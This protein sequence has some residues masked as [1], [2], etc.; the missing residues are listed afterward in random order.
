MDH[1]TPYVRNTISNT[2]V[3]FNGQEY[4]NCPGDSDQWINQ[5]PY[6]YD[7]HE[8][9]DWP[10]GEN[11]P[12]LAAASGEVIEAG[13]IPGFRPLGNAVV[14][15]HGS[16]YETW[17]A[18]LFTSTVNIGDE[19][20]AGQQIALSGNTG[21][22]TG[23]HLHFHVTHNQDI[24]NPFGWRGD[25]PDPLID[26]SNE[27]AVC[28][29]ANEWCNETIVEDGDRSNDGTNRFPQFGSG[30]QWYHKGNSWT[31]KYVPNSDDGSSFAYWIPF[32]DNPGPYEV[33]AFIPAGIGD[34]TTV[35]YTI[36][37]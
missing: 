7:G 8:G 10:M 27:A 30:W 25:T 26:Y 1:E 32:L 28:L 20:V 33:F 23:P 11:T 15:D 31:M 4:N 3:M 16:G 13:V 19:I 22:S 9:I 34:K 21:N 2:I 35:A 6:C 29:W 18:H 14:I 24:T 5:G 37:D 17:Y 12:V 36:H